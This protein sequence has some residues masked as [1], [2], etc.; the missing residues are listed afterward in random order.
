MSELFIWFPTARNSAK[1]MPNIL[2]HFLVE[3]FDPSKDIEGMDYDW[4]DYD[5][6]KSGFPPKSAK[7]RLPSRLIYVVKKHRKLSFDCLS[8]NGDILVVSD[9]FLQFL[10]GN[11]F[12]SAYESAR[13]KVVSDKGAELL[14]VKAYY[15]VR[16]GKFDD[17]L[18]NFPTKGRRRVKSLDKNSHA[19]LYSNLALKAPGKELFALSE[20]CYK[21]YFIFTEQKSKEIARLFYKPEIYPINEFP[22][23]YKAEFEFDW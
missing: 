19:Y 6:I 14:G 8:F 10:D 4:M 5:F 21:G 1:G 3:K 2:E 13:L 17:A 12:K 20:F 23:V 16:I 9:L 11:G 18:F 7:D 22:S 15:A